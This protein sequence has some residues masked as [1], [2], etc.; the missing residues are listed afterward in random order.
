[1]N[2]L[3]EIVEVLNDPPKGDVQLPGLGEED[4]LVGT[5]SNPDEIGPHPEGGQY[6]HVRKLVDYGSKLPRVP[7]PLVLFLFEVLGPVVP[8]FEEF[9]APVLSDFVNREEL[10]IPVV[11][12][13][14]VF[15]VFHSKCHLKAALF[16]HLTSPF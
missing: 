15:I 6:I 14:E 13:Y 12:I 9:N 4:H 11:G 8:L 16:H 1:M 5:V 3:P 2:L 10:R 7:V